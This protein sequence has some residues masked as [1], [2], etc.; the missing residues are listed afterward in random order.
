MSHPKD[1]Y[2]AIDDHMDRFRAKQD[3]DFDFEAEYAKGNVITPDEVVKPP[4]NRNKGKNKGNNGNGGGAP[5]KV[6]FNRENIMR[7]LQEN[8]AD[9]F[10][11]MID[12]MQ[13]SILDDDIRMSAAK[14]LAQY[15]APKLKSVEHKVSD[16]VLAGGIAVLK[17]GSKE[18]KATELDIGAEAALFLESADPPQQPEGDSHVG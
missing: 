11:H 15:I 8:N 16:D 18:D 3:P 12:V 1:E 5:K 6:N 17:F 4:V 10:Q 14:E 13:N 2:S 9:P 7:Q